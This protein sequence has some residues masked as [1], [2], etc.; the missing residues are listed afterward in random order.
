[1]PAEVRSDF[2]GIFTQAVTYDPASTGDAALS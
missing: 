2:G 1:M